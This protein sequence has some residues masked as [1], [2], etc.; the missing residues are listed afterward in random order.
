MKILILNGPNLNKINLRA[1]PIYG[2]LSLEEI[3]ALITQTYPKINFIF[4]QT[5]HEGTMID[6]LQDFDGEAIIINPGAY[7][8]TSIALRDCLEY[9]NILKVE[10]H[11][12]DFTNREDFRKKNYISE[13]V[14]LTISGNYHLG[15]LQAVDYIIKHLK[16]REKYD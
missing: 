8:H 10:V 4:K 1:K 15:Y 12:S 9:L 3:E 5:N 11:L 6:I 13:V 2:S 14:N 16:I 7:T